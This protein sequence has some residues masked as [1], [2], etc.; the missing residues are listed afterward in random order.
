MMTY[1]N[2]FDH[3][4]FVRMNVNCE[5]TYRYSDSAQLF[6]GVCKNLSSSGILFSSHRT[7][8]PGTIIEID[9][10]TPDHNLV[11]SLKALVEVI[12]V[13][14]PEDGQYEVSGEIRGVK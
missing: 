14:G 9:I 2:D 7:I 10:V 4:R 3:R 11:P 6:R 5:L 12:R 8:K 1:V 13:T